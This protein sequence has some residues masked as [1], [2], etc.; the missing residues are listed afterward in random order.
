[1]KNENHKLP[2][3]VINDINQNPVGLAS[4]VW[5]GEK[6]KKRILEDK[7]ILEFN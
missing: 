7:G 5:I 3:S 2:L 4:L 1:M 6:Q